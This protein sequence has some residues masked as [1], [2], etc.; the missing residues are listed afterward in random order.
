MGTIQWRQDSNKSTAN[1]INIDFSVVVEHYRTKQNNNNAIMNSHALNGSK[2]IKHCGGLALSCCEL[3]RYSKP[4]TPFKAPAPQFFIFH[5]HQY[6]IGLLHFS[7]VKLNFLKRA[8]QT[9]IIFL[10]FII[11]QFNLD[12]CIQFYLLLMGSR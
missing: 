1:I 11:N 5:H 9:E 7:F 4:R 2:W 6:H 3:I 8:F 10:L 12:C